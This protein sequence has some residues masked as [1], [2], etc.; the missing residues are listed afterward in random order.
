METKQTHRTTPVTETGKRACSRTNYRK[1]GGTNV[2]QI[3]MTLVSKEELLS[4]REELGIHLLSSARLF[5]KSRNS[6]SSFL[7]SVLPLGGFITFYLILSFFYTIIPL[8][9]SS[10]TTLIFSS[11]SFL[12]VPELKHLDGSCFSAFCLDVFFTFCSSTRHQYHNLFHLNSSSSPLARSILRNK[13]F[14]HFYRQICLCI[15]PLVTTTQVL[16]R[17]MTCGRFQRRLCR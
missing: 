5:G 1:R 9:Y 7:G 16:H 12:F 15:Y 17:T 14:L 8:S 2:S 6:F 3:R 11:S 13:R 4:R 10:L